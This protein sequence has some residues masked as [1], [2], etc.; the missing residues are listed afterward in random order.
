MNRIDRATIHLIGE[1]T[2][3]R[4]VMIETSE[5]DQGDF[6]L[7]TVY[8]KVAPT[9]TDWVSVVYVSDYEPHPNVMWSKEMS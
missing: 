4:D 1:D 9:W 7:V 5:I 2:L 3:D 6:S 8:W